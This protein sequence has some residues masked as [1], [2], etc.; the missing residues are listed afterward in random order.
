[1][2]KVNVPRFDECSKFAF[3][4]MKFTCEV[5]LRGFVLS[6]VSKPTGLL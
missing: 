6:F 1:M 4:Q 5:I 2:A 3:S